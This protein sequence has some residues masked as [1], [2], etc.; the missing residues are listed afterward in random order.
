MKMASKDLICFLCFCQKTPDRLLY[1]IYTIILHPSREKTCNAL[2]LLRLEKK[3][4]RP[5][6]SRYRGEGGAQWR[7]GWEGGGKEGPQPGRPP[8]STV[9]PPS[10]WP[11]RSSGSP[12][13]VNRPFVCKLK[14]HRARHGYSFAVFSFVRFLFL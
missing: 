14:C 4:K 1:Y 6:G 13:G 8:P 12:L 11:L 2:E 7:T 5:R 3:E 9:D 10:E